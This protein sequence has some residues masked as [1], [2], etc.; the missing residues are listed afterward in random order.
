[1]EQVRA[2]QEIV[3]HVNNGTMGDQAERWGRVKEEA[4]ISLKIAELLDRGE[5][6]YVVKKED[7]YILQYDPVVGVATASI[8]TFPSRASLERV[9]ESFSFL[10]AAKLA[11][12]DLDNGLGNRIAIKASL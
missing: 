12:R 4:N 2:R 3:V 10:G 1:M 11:I 9:L 8:G 5:E 7:G 6:P